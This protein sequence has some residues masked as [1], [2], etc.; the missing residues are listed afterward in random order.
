M[1]GFIPK[2]TKLY[3]L[4][5]EFW[6]TRRGCMIFH[7][8]CMSILYSIIEAKLLPWLSSE[9]WNSSRWACIGVVGFRI[10]VPEG[11]DGC[12]ISGNKQRCASGLCWR[13]GARPLSNLHYW[14]EVDSL[15][16]TWSGSGFR[17]E[18]GLRQGKGADVKLL[19]LSN[20]TLLVFSLLPDFLSIIFFSA[21][22]EFT[23]RSDSVFREIDS[24]A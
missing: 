10:K 20:C 3:L 11:G 4:G 14:V 15:Y 12:E 9:F 7:Q 17:I 6:T 8:I 13:R 21:I 23:E 24:L 19:L 2:S 22:R 1:R 18:M 5:T 16:V